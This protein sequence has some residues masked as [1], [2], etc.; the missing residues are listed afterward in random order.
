ME[1]VEYS[2]NR[3]AHAG[4]NSDD[5][6]MPKRQVF[7]QGESQDR[8][9]VFGIR[10]W[11]LRKPVRAVVR[12]YKGLLAKATRF[13]GRTYSPSDFRRRGRKDVSKPRAGKGRI[14]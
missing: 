12:G 1:M 2:R 3:F 10:L 11:V 14:R 8:E 5:P 4:V 7:L 9:I 6:I 13:D